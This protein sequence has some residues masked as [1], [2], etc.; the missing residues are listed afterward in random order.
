MWLTVR[1]FFRE[2]KQILLIAGAV[3]VLGLIVGISAKV[4]LAQEFEIV[5]SSGKLLGRFALTLLFC[6]VLI[7]ISFLNSYLLIC[8][9]A[10]F[11]IAGFKAG[12]DFYFL[13]LAGI[14]GI[15]SMI[16]I[17][18]PACVF[19]FFMLVLALS[20]TLGFS[21]SSPNGGYRNTCRAIQ[22]QMFLNV[23]LVFLINLA[24]VALYI[25]IFG[26]LFNVVV[27]VI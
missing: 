26:S 13:S 17:Y 1:D 4:N 15:F 11:F 3:V 22:W 24:I 9:F 6:Y 18:I 8:A 12:I 27:I 2:C 23:G 25:L 14:N 19:S 21:V 5:S 16:L 20:F 10:A 7:Y